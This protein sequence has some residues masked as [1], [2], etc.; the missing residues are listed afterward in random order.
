[1][2]G[3]QGKYTRKRPAAGSQIQPI[4]HLLRQAYSILLISL[5]KRLKMRFSSRDM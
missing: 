1:M 3:A 5:R 2:A 4:S